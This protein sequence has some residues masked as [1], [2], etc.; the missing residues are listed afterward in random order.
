MRLT[1]HKQLFNFNFLILCILNGTNSDPNYSILS[2]NT[3]TKQGHYSYLMKQSSSSI[4]P[5]NFCNKIII[6]NINLEILI[7]TPHKLN[8]TIKP[9]RV[10][11]I[12]YILEHLERT[13]Q[14]AILSVLL[15]GK[16]LISCQIPY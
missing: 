11:L 1:L 9:L 6:G 4:S 16:L 7:P 2:H 14:A 3:F 5:F 8:V 10:W 13:K 12:L 15:S